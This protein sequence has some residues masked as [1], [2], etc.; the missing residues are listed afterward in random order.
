M[1]YIKNAFCVAATLAEVSPGYRGG[2]V[3]IVETEMTSSGVCGNSGGENDDA[4]GG[5]DTS[6][7]MTSGR[8]GDSGSSDGG[9][10]RSG[11]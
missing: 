1:N 3:A 6:G 5:G 4:A 7:G 9:K 10:S 8:S 2:T 11:T